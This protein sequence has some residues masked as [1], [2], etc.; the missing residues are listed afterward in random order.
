MYD[1]KFKEGDHVTIVNCGELS[2]LTGTIC[3]VSSVTGPPNIPGH[4]AYVIKLDKPLSNWPFTT[5]V[6]TD[7]CIKRIDTI[8]I[9]RTLFNEMK[10][11]LALTQNMMAYLGYLNEDNTP[12]KNQVSF[13]APHEVARVMKSLNNLT[14]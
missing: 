13:A 14:K 4:V 9:E 12:N 2:D 6:I 8:E 5:V 1:F 7:A 3:G 10:Q 11:A